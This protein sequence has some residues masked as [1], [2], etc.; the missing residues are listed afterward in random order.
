MPVRDGDHPVG[1]EEGMR[2]LLLLLGAF[3]P[4]VVHAED[5]EVLVAKKTI[6]KDF[7]IEESMVTYK[8]IPR[9]YVQPRA[10]RRFDETLGQIAEVTIFEGAQITS[11]QLMS[12]EDA[13]LTFSIPKNYRAFTLPLDQRR[14]PIGDLRPG[15]YVDLVHVRPAAGGKSTEA[16]TLL[17]NVYVLAVGEDRRQTEAGSIDNPPPRSAKRRAEA[18]TITVMLTPQEVQAVA[19][20]AETGGVRISLRSLWEGNTQVP[21]QKTTVPAP[22]RTPYPAETPKP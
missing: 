12:I 11:T 3:A 13:G 7:K 4:W 22:M 2:F 1:V 18:E 14:A 16:L 8:L 9:E 5:V 17:Q 6:P 10:L 19:A 21:L 15:N 20:A